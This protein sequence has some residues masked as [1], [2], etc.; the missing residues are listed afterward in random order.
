M[1]SQLTRPRPV[2]LCA[3]AVKWLKQ[4]A[5]PDDFYK[6]QR[7]FHDGVRPLRAAFCLLLAL[8]KPRCTGTELGCTAHLLC[9]IGGMEVLT[10]PL[11]SNAHRCPSLQQGAL[12]QLLEM[13][14]FLTL[15][16]LF[17][18]ELH[19]S[20]CDQLHLAS[21]RPLVT[22]LQAVCRLSRR[23]GV[24]Q[25]PVYPMRLTCSSRRGRTPGERLSPA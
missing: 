11:Q 3:E 24:Q 16:G 9:M 12:S 14:G 2:V 18:L 4:D 10:D 1:R 5:G 20:R 8:L 15:K 7:A 23:V 25:R 13:G 19:A 6:Y 17:L 22:H 21:R